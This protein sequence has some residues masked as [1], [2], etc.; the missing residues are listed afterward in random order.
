MFNALVL[1]RVDGRITP[2]VRQ[3]DDQQLPDGGV[4]V[5]V[6]YSS[7]NY[8]DVMILQGLGGMVRSYPHIPGV[9]FAGRVT[10]SHDDQWRVGDPVVLTGHRVGESRFGGYAQRA[11]VPGDWLIHLPDGM[12]TRTA[13]ALG[14]AGL[15][16]MLSVHALEHQGLT[17]DGL[18]VLV[19]GATGGVGSVSIMLLH[20]LGYTVHAST[21]KTESQGYLRSLGA[22]EIIPRNEL[23]KPPTKALDRQMWAGCIDSVG[24]ETLAHVL[25]RTAERG[26]VVTVGLTG[27]DTLATSLTPFLLRGVNLLGIASASCPAERRLSA[28]HRLAEILPND[29]L[30]RITRTVGLADLPEVAKAFLAGNAHGR[31]VVDV[32]A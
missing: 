19:T 2:V 15:T 10:E 16:A 23:S 11:R 30:E 9:D 5:A 13:M 27:G 28:W 25:S 29:K 17:P 8:K 7:V 3:L 20:R 26:A 12:T 31:T 18:P 4:T 32:N 1:D 24:G 6:E 21:G 22:T 14:T